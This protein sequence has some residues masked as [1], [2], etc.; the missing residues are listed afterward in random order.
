MSQSLSL[1]ATNKIK[2][3]LINKK[4]MFKNPLKV[5]SDESSA[6]STE[7]Y[8][9]ENSSEFESNDGDYVKKKVKIDEK[10]KK[11][12]SK[13][14]ADKTSVLHNKKTV[15]TTTNGT[16][17]STVAKNDVNK[18]K[19]AKKPANSNT[20]VKTA[21][22]KKKLLKAISN[23]LLKENEKIKI[24]SKDPFFED[25]VEIPYVSSEI[26]S[27]LA[28]RAIE[29]DDMK[30]L[31]KLI[32]DR[33][34]VSRLDCQKSIYNKITP[35]HFAIKVGRKEAVELLIN[36]YLNETERVK[37]PKAMLSK[38]TTG[39]WNNNTFNAHYIRPLAQSRGSK[40]GNNAFL[41]DCEPNSY[42][43]IQDL[44]DFCFQN[45]CSIEIFDYICEK[46]ID[47]KQFLKV[48]INSINKAVLN[49]N[50]K[51]A[52]R[53]I[54]KCESY[55]NSEGFNNLHVCVLSYDKSEELKSQQLRTQ[56]CLKK[57][58]MNDSVTPLHFSCINPNTKYLK[59]LINTT[60]EVNLADKRGRKLIHYAATCEDASTLEYLMLNRRLSQY[61]CDSMGNTLCLY[62]W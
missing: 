19:M 32:D 1:I 51:L 18:E 26:Q 34:S 39:H 29:L 28:F 62:F 38:F 22:E 16:P 5:E 27:K 20:M 48:C 8:S 6:S 42:N 21:A 35:L 49:G 46:L 60:Q 41:K 12:T 4:S 56:T 3:D 24:Y 37:M 14:A 13:I 2:K 31:Q 9:S 53:V 36:E 25:S 50:R 15:Q 59:I 52:A 40:E 57:A 43:F 30:L 7:K 23:R 17:K 55:L 54:D 61:E 33:K 58:F 45:N 44:I 47:N 11:L 10:N